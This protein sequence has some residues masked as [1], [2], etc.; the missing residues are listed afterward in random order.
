MGR[1][2]KH[3]ELVQSSNG[4]SNAEKADLEKVLRRWPNLNVD[5]L[6]LTRNDKRKGGSVFLRKFEKGG[7]EWGAEQRVRI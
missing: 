7:E 6:T 1:K 4:K 2:S 3:K 5:D